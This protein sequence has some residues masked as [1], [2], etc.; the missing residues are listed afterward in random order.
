MSTFVKNIRFECDFEGAKVVALLRS[1]RYADLLRLE[2]IEVIPASD[3]VEDKKKQA[4]AEDRQVALAL[5]EI[6]PTHIIELQGPLDAE[7]KQV[8]VEDLCSSA[9]FTALIIAMGKR[10]LVESSPKVRGKQLA[11][12]ASSSKGRRGRS[13]RT[14]GG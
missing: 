11:P 4:A 7:G 1:L 13:S 14:T 9:Y 2:G 8:S 12:S 10:L 3:S 6:L 5:G